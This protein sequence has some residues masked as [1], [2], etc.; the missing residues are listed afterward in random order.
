MVHIK[1]DVTKVKYG[2][3]QYRRIHKDNKF[4]LLRYVPSKAYKAGETISIFIPYCLFVRAVLINQK[5]PSPRSCLVYL[6][7][8]FF[9]DDEEHSRLVETIVWGRAAPPFPIYTSSC[10]TSPS[11]SIVRTHQQRERTSVVVVVAGT[12]HVTNKCRLK[13]KENRNAGFSGV[14]FTPQNTKLWKKCVLRTGII[15]REKNAFRSG[16]KREVG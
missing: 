9:D 3:L 6:S 7:P 1:F 8:V 11:W 2:R 4:I 14:N 15:S 16:D 13:R 5:A 10:H 12:N